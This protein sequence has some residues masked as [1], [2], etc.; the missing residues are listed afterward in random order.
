MADVRRRRG[1]GTWVVWA[2]GSRARLRGR[3]MTTGPGRGA[4]SIMKAVLI[5]LSTW[6]GSTN[7]VVHFVT[8]PKTAVTGSSLVNR[9]EKISNRSWIGANNRTGTE[10]PQLFTIPAMALAAPGPAST[11][12]APGSPVTRAKPSQMS[13]A[14]RSWRQYSAVRPSM[15]S[16]AETIS[17]AEPPITPAMSR[18]PSSRHIS[19]ICSATFIGRTPFSADA[20]GS[21]RGRSWPGPGR[22]SPR[23]RSER[24]AVRHRTSARCRAAQ[25]MGR[26]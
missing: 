13:T 20:A 1:T 6:L 4:L 19:A 11:N 18:T 21:S 14:T 7:F 16:R 10:S 12:T 5:A 2:P 8:G 24:H 17:V 3:P 26:L 15:P 23:G 25:G 9:C 22:S